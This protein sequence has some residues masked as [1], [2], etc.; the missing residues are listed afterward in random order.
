[1]RASLRPSLCGSAR[2]QRGGIEYLSS[3]CHQT[4]TKK[5]DSGGISE[6]FFAFKGTEFLVYWP[7]LLPVVD[8]YG[9]PS[10]ETAAHVAET[11]PLEPEDS[12]QRNAKFQEWGNH[13]PE[14][15]DVG[16]WSAC[17]VAT[18]SQVRTPM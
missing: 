14:N 1:M 6:P 2:P 5:N 8:R 17:E 10:R 9:E 12:A 16:G 15:A 3:S 7:H 18:I 4:C 13:L 11:A